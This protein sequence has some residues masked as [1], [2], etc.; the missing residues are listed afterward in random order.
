MKNAA[1]T[2]CAADD[3]GVVESSS[4]T[5]LDR[6]PRILIVAALCSGLMA[7]GL[8]FKRDVPVEIAALLLTAC[9]TT[10][11][12]V[13]WVRKNRG[14]RWHRGA[15]IERQALAGRYDH[16]SRSCCPSS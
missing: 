4:G 11:G 12:L 9:L 8:V 16:L 14:D 15:Q 3:K 5:R 7:V 2:V 10:S 1:K 13:C 6:P